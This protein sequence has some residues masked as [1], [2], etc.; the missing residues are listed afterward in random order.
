M[1]NQNWRE[2]SPHF[3]SELCAVP[4]A[5][6]GW[7]ELFGKPRNLLQVACLKQS[8]WIIRKNFRKYSILTYFLSD[9]FPWLYSETWQIDVQLV[10]QHA[11]H[12]YMTFVFK[13][14]VMF[15]WN[16]T[17]VRKIPTFWLTPRIWGVN[18][19]FCPGAWDTWK[20][21]NVTCPKKIV[22]NSYEKQLNSQTYPI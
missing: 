5:S 15:S 17:G 4:G 7:Q 19:R 11:L 2:N 16:L 8:T 9:S 14:L 1:S 12:L 21:G 10:K 6:R 20:L 22:Y 13:G 18:L 3:Y